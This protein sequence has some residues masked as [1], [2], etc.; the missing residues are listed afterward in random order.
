MH[1]K[2]F[3]IGKLHFRHSLNIS[4]I[5]WDRAM[6]W[7]SCLP[8]ISNHAHSSCWQTWTAT[9]AAVAMAAQQG[10]FN[11]HPSAHIPLQ[12]WPTLPDTQDRG[13][14]MKPNYFVWWYNLR[15][16]FI[17]L[18]VLTDPSWRKR[19]PTA[20]NIW[21]WILKEHMNF[22]D[23]INYKSQQ[24]SIHIQ[25]LDNVTSSDKMMWTTLSDKTMISWDKNHS[26]TEICAKH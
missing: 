4:V 22:S 25:T 6:H 12:T 15:S 14:E 13:D 9:A 21:F 16:I 19:Y 1:G 24:K 7:S 23:E 17:S 10:S 5:L 20:R 2:F 11:C 18:G 26:A 8:V 3:C